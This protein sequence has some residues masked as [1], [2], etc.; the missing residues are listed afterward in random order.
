ME[1]EEAEKA[2]TDAKLVIEKIEETSKKVEEGYVIKQDPQEGTELNAGDTVKVYVSIGT[3]IEQVPV[4]SVVGKTE[5]AAKKA[6]TDAKL[7]VQVV[8]EEDTTK[9]NG[10]VLKQSLDVGDVVDADTVV[11]IT[12]NK[13]S[14]L[15]NGTVNIRLKT[16]LNYKEEQDEE[17]NVVEPED[18]QV[19]VLVDDDEVY[20]RKHSE[21]TDKITVGIQGI[22]TVYVKVYV[23]TTLYAQTQMN[24]NDANPVWTAE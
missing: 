24:M 9:T 5:E 2:L 8:Y 22:G 4:P 3:G 15:K 13:I 20:N 17:G 7:K 14:E 19:K 21:D 6:L 11:T 18:V 1:I 16:L 12:V 23:G 10:T